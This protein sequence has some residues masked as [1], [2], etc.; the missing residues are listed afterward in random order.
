MT[1]VPEDERRGS[2]QREAVEHRL[3]LLQQREALTR[4]GEVQRVLHARPAQDDVAIPL[5]RP[6]QRARALP[7]REEGVVLIG[8]ERAE[9]RRRGQLRAHV[10]LT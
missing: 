4:P 1:L 10:D 8:A 3:R 9:Q 7:R 6:Q 5:R 2:E